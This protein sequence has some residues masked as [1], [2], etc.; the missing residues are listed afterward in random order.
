MRDIILSFLGGFF[1]GV[2]FN[3]DR[4]NLFWAGVSGTIGWEVFKLCGKSSGST[5]F[6]ALI[7]AF[8]VGVYGEALARIRKSPALVYTIPGIFP[9]VPGINAYNTVL[10]I[11]EKRISDAYYMGIE[12]IGIAG[13]IAFGI[14]LATAFFKFGKKR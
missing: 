6:G 7:G 8:C 4:K 12:T 2:F 9:L 13:A 11:V 10:A 5:V 1:P 14:M 3:I